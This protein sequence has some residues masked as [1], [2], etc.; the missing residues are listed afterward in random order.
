MSDLFDSQTPNNR[1]RLIERLDHMVA[2]GQVTADEA[3]RLR[4]ANGAT[5]IDAVITDI[6]LGH[7]QRSLD[8]AVEAGQMTR[9]EADHNLERLRNGE[10]PRGLR[11]HLRKIAPRR[12]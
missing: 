2:S 5:E 8:A 12:H 3:G 4:A 6:R 10:H 11:A 7:A 9:S 1:K